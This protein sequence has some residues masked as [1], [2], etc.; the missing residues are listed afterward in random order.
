MTSR[1]PKVEG[2]CDNCGS[3]LVQRDD[4][5]P[6]SVRVRMAAYKKSTAPLA[7][8]YRKLRLL[9]EVDAH[10]SPEADFPADARYA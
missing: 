5:R 4:D 2:I 3:Q 9:V 10:G 6:E 7:D 1:P 8:Y